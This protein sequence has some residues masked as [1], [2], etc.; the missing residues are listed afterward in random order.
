M[1]WT[2]KGPRSETT[3]FDH[4]HCIHIL[5]T[6]K[7]E[8]M[9][10]TVYGEIADPSMRE[11]TPQLITSKRP[12]Q[13]L[14]SYCVWIIPTLPSEG[15]PLKPQVMNVTQLHNCSKC[16]HHALPPSCTPIFLRGID[17]F[18]KIAEKDN[19]KRC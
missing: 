10:Q 6:Q 18:I 2:A 9:V 15:A 1:G 3:S 5:C 13:P 16:F 12:I 17:N 7:D 19:R 4:F 8:S 11:K 14:P